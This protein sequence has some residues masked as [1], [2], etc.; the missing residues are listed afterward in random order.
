MNLPPE[1]RLTIL[2]EVDDE[3]LFS[4]RLVSRLL[5]RESDKEFAGR[6]LT[7]IPMVGTVAEVQRLTKVLHS[8]NL[9]HLTSNIKELYVRLPNLTDLPLSEDGYRCESLLSKKCVLRLL[10][11]MPVLE[12]FSLEPPE[13]GTDEDEVRYRCHYQILSK[14]QA[15]GTIFLSAVAGLSPQASNLTT[16]VIYDL[17]FD[18]KD[19][20]D[21][22]SAHRASL[23]MV[24]ITQCELEEVRKK[25][26]TWDQIFSTLLTMELDELYLSDIVESRSWERRVLCARSNGDGFEHHWSSSNP[27]Q[28]ATPI[29]LT[30]LDLNTIDFNEVCDADYYAVFSKHMAH[31]HRDWVKK[32]LEILLGLK[33]YP[34]YRDPC[35][36]LGIAG[37]P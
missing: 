20:L 11:A 35:Q 6:F 4:L 13:E 37:R 9:A 3:D 16:L 34:L 14:S 12:D 26:V 24:D 29:D 2:S 19:L 25:P 33:N 1:L 15:I 22:L 8:P 7:S 5:L 23:R 31:L 32:G 28:R 17:P 10:R 30:N 36:P 21:V 27:L 18:G